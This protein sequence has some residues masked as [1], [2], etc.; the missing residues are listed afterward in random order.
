MSERP[1][2]DIGHN[3]GP[4]LDDE[5]VPEWGRPGQAHVYLAW[6]HAHAE[7]W[8]K[9]PWE[10][11][12][13][14]ARKAEAIGLTYEEYTLELLERGRY[15]GP[16]DVDRIEAIK[17]ARPRPTLLASQGVASE[18]SPSRKTLARGVATPQPLDPVA[19]ARPHSV[20]NSSKPA[21]PADRK[22]GLVGRARWPR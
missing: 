15:L 6:R 7:V 8:K 16:A 19:S 11:M 10:T 18:T 14:R 17:A 3:G 21:R 5:H 13:R 4:P 12:I 2:S 1:L 22:P 20:S 9:V